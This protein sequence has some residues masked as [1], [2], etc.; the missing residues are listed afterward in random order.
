MFGERETEEPKD[1]NGEPRRKIQKKKLRGKNLQKKWKKYLKTGKR[2][3]NRRGLGDR[4]AR[5]KRRE[6]R[7]GNLRRPIPP[8]KLPRPIHHSPVPSRLFQPRLE[9][10]HRLPTYVTWRL[11][12][13][14]QFSGDLTIASTP[15]NKNSSSCL[16]FTT[17]SAPFSSLAGFNCNVMTIGDKE[18]F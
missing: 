3:S 1:Q 5:S 18:L 12:Y 8:P 15:S 17:V 6:K 4:K 14:G 10:V 11:P 13:L 7:K 2:T 9:L 16:R